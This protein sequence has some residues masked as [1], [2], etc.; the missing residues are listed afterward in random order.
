[1]SDFPGVCDC[2][3]TQPAKPPLGLKPFYVHRA[4]RLSD[5]AHAMSRYVDAGMKIPDAWIAEFQ[6]LCA[7]Y[8]AEEV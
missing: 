6:T 5:I 8:Y 3:K 7:T 2:R 1:V 4:E